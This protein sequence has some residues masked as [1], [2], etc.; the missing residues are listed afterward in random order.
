MG[1]NLEENFVL[2]GDESEQETLAVQPPQKKRK[3]RETLGKSEQSAEGQREMMEA[4]LPSVDLENFRFF[5]KDATAE[6]LASSNV[7]IGSFF[8][9]DGARIL[10]L[11]S[12]AKRVTDLAES[13]EFAKFKP[14]ALQFHGTGRKQEQLAKM[15]KD[16]QSG[17][18][19]VLIGVSARVARFVEEDVI[20]LAD[21]A[22]IAIDTAV[23]AKNF[24]TLS[25]Q[26]SKQAL[27]EIFADKSDLSFNLVLF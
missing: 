17:K 3:L 21:F 22:L 27:A 7:E 8:Q 9:D 19:R 25:Q 1:D 23:D 14:L 11:T 2:G 26:E 5:E 10:V 4:A 6:S 24:N 15:R 16:I 20:D 18:S 12:S 13:A